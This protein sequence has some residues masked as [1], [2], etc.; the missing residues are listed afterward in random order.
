[1]PTSR[2][3]LSFLTWLACTMFAPGGMKIHSGR[4]RSAP[5]D[6]CVTLPSCSIPVASHRPMAR[7][8]S[9][10]AYGAPMTRVA[11]T[12]RYRNIRGIRASEDHDRREAYGHQHKYQ[13]I[14]P[15]RTCSMWVSQPVYGLKVC[16]LYLYIRYNAGYG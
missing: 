6:M 11:I 3:C 4:G 13:E 15:H 12:I 7:S 2:C 14:R 8:M 16:C 1:M 10:A 9:N 5:N